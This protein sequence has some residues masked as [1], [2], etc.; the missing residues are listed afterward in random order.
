MAGTRQS[1]RAL[2]NR[3]DVPPVAGEVMRKSGIDY[4]QNLVRILRI[5]YVFNLTNVPLKHCNRSNLKHLWFEIERLDSPCNIYETFWNPN[6][7]G[8]WS[9]SETFT[10]AQDIMFVVWF[11]GMA[12]TLQRHWLKTGWYNA[13]NN[14]NFD[15]S[16]QVHDPGKLDV[17]LLI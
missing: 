15:F 5:Y 1:F 8:K 10:P 17:A 11:A 9:R 2:F 14:T 12:L 6:S 16:F 13:N 3:S 7:L 4:S